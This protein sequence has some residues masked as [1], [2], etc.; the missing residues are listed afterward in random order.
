MRRRLDPNAR[1]TGL[2]QVLA[3]VACFVW[4][5]LDW[6]GFI[7]DGGYPGRGYLV[8]SIAPFM[9]ADGLRRLFR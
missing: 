9:L 4:A 3:S 8:L 5:A 1:S 7:N 6:N 2:I